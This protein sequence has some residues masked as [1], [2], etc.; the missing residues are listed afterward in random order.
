MFAKKRKQFLPG[1]G[2][3]PTSKAS[4][5]LRTERDPEYPKGYPESLL[6]DE[7]E[8]AKNRLSMYSFSFGKILN[9]IVYIAV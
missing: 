6:A 2:V 9:F 7:V 3:S 4:A 1:F 8:T 5:P